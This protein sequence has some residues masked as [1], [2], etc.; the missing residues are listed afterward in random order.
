VTL[1]ACGGGSDNGEATAT[2]RGEGGAG[3]AGAVSIKSIGDA[4]PVLVDS[5]GQALY[6]SNLEGSGHVVC[7]GACTSFWQPLTTGETAPSA[8]SS[9]PGKLGIV[10]RPDG[11]RQVSYAG[12][13]LYTF[14]QEGPEEV[15]GD[16][17][18]DDFNGQQFTWSVVAVEAGAGESSG[19]GSGAEPRDYGGEPESSGTGGYGY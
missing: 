13:P 16:G 5:S 1:A 15:T 7:T 2:M 3:G 9:L 8:S 18:V 19:S 4:G 10:T 11:T 14:T 17:F 12:N 6:T